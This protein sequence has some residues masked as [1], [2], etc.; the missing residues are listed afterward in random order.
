VDFKGPI[1][2]GRNV[3]K[4]AVRPSR[5]AAD[6]QDGIAGA[7]YRVKPMILSAIQDAIDDEFEALLS[8]SLAPNL[9]KDFTCTSADTALRQPVTTA[10]WRLE[11]GR[12]LGQRPSVNSQTIS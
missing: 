10:M 4:W 8:S 12:V 5:A 11:L 9:L 7:L 2:D 1:A 3:I 6:F